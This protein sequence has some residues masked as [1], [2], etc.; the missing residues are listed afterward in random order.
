[1]MGRRG[2]GSLEAWGRTG[3]LGGAA[4]LQGDTSKEEG[5]G[6]HLE[7]RSRWRRSWWQGGGAGFE[8]KLQQHW[9]AAEMK[10]I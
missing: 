9:R 5:E 2:T 4:P 6:G 10:K 8:D 1:M 7:D 3:T